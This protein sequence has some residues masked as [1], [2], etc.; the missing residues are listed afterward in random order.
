MAA[1][2]DHVADALV[3]S[4]VSQRD[5]AAFTTLGA[6][7][8]TFR[9]E[10]GSALNRLNSTEVGLEPS[11]TGKITVLLKLCE[12]CGRDGRGERGAQAATLSDL[13]SG[14]TGTY[15]ERPY[16]V[17]IECRQKLSYVERC[18]PVRGIDG[19]VPTMINLAGRNFDTSFSD[20]RLMGKDLTGLPGFWVYYSNKGESVR[21]RRLRSADLRRNCAAAI[22]C[23]A[24]IANARGLKRCRGA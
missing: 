14:H 16:K 18:P 4:L 3:D 12:F 19:L 13:V 8:K 11:Y 24:D 21:T 23:A 1:R 20:R 2:L 17:C 15:L 6:T 9:N 7:C 22:A 5:F 10:I